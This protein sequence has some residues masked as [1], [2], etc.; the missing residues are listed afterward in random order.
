[1]NICE[2]PDDLLQTF[3]DAYPLEKLGPLALSCKR[4]HDLCK[5]RLASVRVLLRPPFCCPSLFESALTLR[6]Q[7]AD[8]LTAFLRAVRAGALPHLLA[9]E[10]FRENAL[11]DRGLSVLA[12]ALADGT[13]RNLMYLNLCFNQI[14]DA[15]CTALFKPCVKLPDLRLLT[16]GLPNLTMLWIDENQIGDDGMEVFSEACRDGSLPQLTVLQLA[17]NQIG[18]VGL[19]A[20]ANA[21]AKGALAKLEILDLQL[22]PIGDVGLTAFADACAKGSSPSL[23]ELWI[24]DG[25]LG[26]DHPKLKAACEERGIELN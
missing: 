23:K 7:T 15:S 26:V 20:L 9:L 18:D 8:D 19:T 10:V 1:M 13:L 22:N 21:C 11:G 2:L 3:V 25:P 4:V 16:V 5:G 17:N 14:S 6:C 24:H 12:E